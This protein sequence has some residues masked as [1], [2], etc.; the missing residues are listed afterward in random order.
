MCACQICSKKLKYSLINMGKVPIA[1]HLILKQGTKKKTFNLEV[2]LCKECN[3]Y[4]LGE[5]LSPKVIFD[6]Y[7]YHSSYS[8]SFLEHSKNLYKQYKRN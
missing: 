2:F 7:F 4:Q 1:N 8:S 3:L 6:N 5:R